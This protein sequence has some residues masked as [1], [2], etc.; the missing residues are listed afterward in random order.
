[1]AGQRKAADKS[2]AKNELEFHSSPEVRTALIPGKTFAGK[3]VQ[4]AVVDGLAIFEGDIV[5]GTVEEVE[6]DDRAA[7]RRDRGA[8]VAAVV[9]T[10]P[11]FRW[12][13]CRIPFTIDP[14]LPNQNRVTEAIA[15]WEA[16]T[17]FR[18]VARTQ[19]SDGLRHLPT[20]QRLFV[21]GR[22]ARRPAVRQ[23][24]ARLRHRAATIHEIGHVVGL[25]HEQSR[26]DRDLFV[27]INFHKI[28]PGMEHNF[29]Q[30][31]TDGDDVGATTTARSCT[32]RAT[33]SRSTAATRSRRRLRAR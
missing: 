6:R 32:T 18:F 29:D 22:P 27:T 5:L 26:E 10:G 17:R 12:P 31:I 15:H 33:R 19:R 24:R 1:M 2:A 9:I 4:Y 30:H 8:G 20:G 11:Q 21:A 25:W 3:A 7:A 13:N 23:S 28:E 16:N 14:A